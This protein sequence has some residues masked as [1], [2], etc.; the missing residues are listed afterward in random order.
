M[1]RCGVVSLQTLAIFTKRKLYQT[2][3]TS[4]NLY[5][6]VYGAM[7]LSRSEQLIQIE[8]DLSSFRVSLEL[9]LRVF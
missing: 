3:V 7:W 8:N 6:I 5:Y 2:K 9:S 4:Y 1:P